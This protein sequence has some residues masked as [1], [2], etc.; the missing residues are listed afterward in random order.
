[1]DRQRR[2]WGTR[3]LSLEELCSKRLKELLEVENEV[4]KLGVKV[5]FGLGWGEPPKDYPRLLEEEMQ[6]LQEKLKRRFGS[7][8]RLTENEI[9]QAYRKF[10]WRIG[11]DPTK[12]RP[13]GEA[14]ARR[15]LRG[16]QL[17]K[18][19]PI[20]DIGN[21]VSAETLVP[22]GIYDL[23]KATI[24]LTL[25]LTRG[26]EEFKPIGGKDTVLE[27][28]IPVL[29][30]SKGTVMHVYPHRDSRLTCVTENTRKVLVL[31]AGV[32]GVPEAHVVKAAKR[33]LE[34]LEECLKWRICGPT[35]K[36]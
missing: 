33:V 29:V 35:T 14:L 11:I 23:D 16:K 15:V 28:N 34:L 27:D 6:A 5:A 22:I 17:P 2:A 32:P 36:P 1:M 30:D 21:I 18:I 3:L 20:V 10:Y 19:N 31:A 24:P 26:G 12:T 7:V 9:V 13:S 8:E 4:A 25:K